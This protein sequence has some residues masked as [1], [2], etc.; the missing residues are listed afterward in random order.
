MPFLPDNPLALV[1]MLLSLPLFSLVIAAVIVVVIS[2]SRRTARASVPDRYARELRALGV[3]AIGVIVVFA[4]E[5][6]VRG[7]VLCMVGR[8]LVDVVDWWRYPTPILAAALGLAVVVVLIATSGTV[9]PEEPVLPT[10]RRTW[11]TFGPRGGLVAAGVTLVTLVTTTVA[12]G[13]VSSSDENGRFIYLEL[14]APNTSIE[15]VRPW[16]YGWSYGVPVLISV[17]LLG[18]VTWVLLTRNS[19]RPFLRADTM[20]AEQGARTDVASA[21]VRI[22]TAGSLL[23]LGGVFRFVASA[24]ISSVSINGGEPYEVAWRYAALT[25]AAGWVAPVLEVIGFSLLLLVAVRSVRARAR[26][27][28]PVAEAAVR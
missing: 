18:L 27:V 24:N 26:V 20:P 1:Q 7:Y 21:A 9:A 11:T 19:A 28:E 15:P 23:A 6:I 10:S 17:V 12:S 13:L 14:S 4:I 8:C 16:F 3:V 2:V 5:N 22:A 25:S